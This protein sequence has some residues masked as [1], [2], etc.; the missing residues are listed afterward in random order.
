MVDFLLKP[1]STL[2]LGTKPSHRELVFL[3]WSF[4]PHVGHGF[5]FGSLARFSIARRCCSASLSC[6]F[7]FLSC[8]FFSNFWR[9]FL[10]VASSG[11]SARQFIIWHMLMDGVAYM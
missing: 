9:I 2:R 4:L 11:G 1:V 7:F 6:A 10:M 8:A 3:L 5:A